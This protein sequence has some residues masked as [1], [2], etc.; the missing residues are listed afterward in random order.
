MDS[1]RLKGKMIE[2]KYTQKKMA[3]ELGITQ[4]SLS[5]KI[6][7]RTQFTLK[8]IVHIVEKLELENDL[9]IFIETKMS[10]VQRQENN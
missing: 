8:E 2:K 10:K 4:Q 6:N 5:S 3:L 9:D 1:Y 7:N